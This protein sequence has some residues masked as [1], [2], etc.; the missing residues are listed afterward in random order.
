M[1]QPVW[2]TDGKKLFLT[3]DC[4]DIFVWSD[5]SLTRLFVD[6]ARPRVGYDHSSY[7]LCHMAGE[8]AL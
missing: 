5:F 4:L 7:A 2:K 3:E 8:D 6:V 1:I